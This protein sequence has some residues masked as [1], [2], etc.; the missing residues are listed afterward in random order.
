MNLMSY[1]DL[2]S[3]S[4]FLWIAVRCMGCGNESRTFDFFMDLSLSIPGGKVIVSRPKVEV[5][6]SRRKRGAKTAKSKKRKQQQ[7]APRKQSV[8]PEESSESVESEED[9]K[10]EQLVSQ[11][12]EGHNRDSNELYARLDSKALESVKIPYFNSYQDTLFEP[13]YPIPPF[14]KTKKSVT[15]LDCLNEFSS[16][17]LLDAKKN[18]YRCEKCST[19]SNNCARPSSAQPSCARTSCA[20]PS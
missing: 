18:F 11:A 2:P 10:L 1:P 6:A 20:R 5:V 16:Y 19:T 14:D 15:L 3:N 12:K 7:R 4:N 13:T 17:E 9:A 8:E